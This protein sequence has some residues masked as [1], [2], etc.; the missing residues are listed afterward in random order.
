MSCAEFE[1]LGGK[2]QAKKWKASIRV[3]GGEHDNMQIGTYL[4][5]IL[6]CDINH[7]VFS[8]H[9]PPPKNPAQ[10]AKQPGPP[11]SQPTRKPQAKEQAQKKQKRTEGSGSDDGD[12]EGERLPRSRSSAAG[13]L[14]S[15][16]LLAHFAGVRV[17]WE[18]GSAAGEVQED[19]AAE[20]NL[21]TLTGA[22]HVPS[23]ADSL[24]AWQE[25]TKRLQHDASVSAA[26]DA[27]SSLAQPAQVHV[28]LRVEQQSSHISVQL[29]CQDSQP[30]PLEP[31]YRSAEQQQTSGAAD[32]PS[33]HRPGSPVQQ[34]TPM[35]VD[36]QAD[37]VAQASALR[38]ENSRM[39]GRHPALL[40]L[41]AVTPAQLFAL[42]QQHGADTAFDGC[43]LRR[44]RSL[45]S[46]LVCMLANHVQACAS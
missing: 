3:Y 9:P 33:M 5:T 8:P 10:P 26:A 14:S 15:A 1:A 36:V 20:D 37:G 7:G 12:E 24:A 27:A 32:A 40:D 46:C 41:T 30:Q 42:S 11:K 4:H 2:A 38:L 31:D 39:R 13:Q 21:N 18:A 35:D 22:W 19:G 23:Q 45:F 28:R 34:P 17:G 6:K 29:Q 25:R 44:V 16:A 43:L